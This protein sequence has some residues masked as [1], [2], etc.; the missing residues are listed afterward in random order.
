MQFFYISATSS[1]FPAFSNK[2]FALK[3]NL[4]LLLYDPDQDIKWINQSGDI[5]FTIW[6][7]K[8]EYYKNCNTLL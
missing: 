6:G 7:N 5:K 3:N 8:K 1:Y 2:I 4:Y